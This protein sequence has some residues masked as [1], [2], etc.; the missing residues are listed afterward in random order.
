MKIATGRVI[1]GKVVMRDSE[2]P[3]GDFRN[4]YFSGD[5]KQQVDERVQAILDELAVERDQLA[6]VALR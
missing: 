2:F 6:E 5:R 4:H 1:D 3:E